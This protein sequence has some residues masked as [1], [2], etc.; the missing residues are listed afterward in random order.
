MKSVNHDTKIF[1]Q[2]QPTVAW[3]IDVICYYGL[4]DLCS[5]TYMIINHDMHVS[6]A[7]RW[8]SETSSFHLLIS[9]MTITLDDISCL[10]HLPIRGRLMDHRRIDIP[11]TLYLDVFFFCIFGQ[12]LCMVLTFW[13]IMYDFFYFPLKLI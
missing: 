1:E 4:A 3:F 13:I 5:S 6:F 2:E 8:H 7:V 11:N 9:Q 10:L 12:M